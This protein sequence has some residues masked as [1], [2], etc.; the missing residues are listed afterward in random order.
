MSATLPKRV[1]LGNIAPIQL[2]D[3]HKLISYR[4]A[5]DGYVD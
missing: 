4:N 1:R 3:N 5:Y 2:P